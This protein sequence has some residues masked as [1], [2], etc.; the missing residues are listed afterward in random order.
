MRRVLAIPLAVA[1]GGC[2]LIPWSPDR[3]DPGAVSGPPVYVEGCETCHAAPV[4]KAY[5]ASLH[6]AQGIRCGQ[7]HTGEGHPDFAQPVRDGKC[8]GCHQAEYQQ[9][10][11]SK[12]FA[13]RLQRALD[14]DRAARAALRR[15]GFTGS[16]AAGRAF[17][18]DVGSGELGG[19]L[20]A[21]CHYDEHR[22][23]L[24]AVQGTD[25]CA[26]CHTRRDE[27]FPIPASEPEN[28]CVT[29][30]VRAGE[31]ASGQVVNTHRFA[32]PG[33]GSGGP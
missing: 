18:G 14:G 20:C 6:A 3:P 13:T 15:E 21:A 26:A 10:L 27:H 9:T 5:A 7:C 25:G 29:C 32:L 28:R 16:T 33:A 23:G 19:R 2:F 11:V 24:G 1:L 17:V 22:L 12:H 31:T 4:G 8:G 30:H